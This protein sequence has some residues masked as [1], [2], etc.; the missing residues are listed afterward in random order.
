MPSEQR[1]GERS[2]P[3]IGIAFLHGVIGD[4][5][6]V[7][8]AEIQSDERAVTAIGVLRRAVAWFAERGVTVER[9]LPDNGWPT[10]PTPGAAPAPN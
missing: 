5:S 9:V 4:H 1:S 3:K 2:R 6:R 7:A 10:C 8:H